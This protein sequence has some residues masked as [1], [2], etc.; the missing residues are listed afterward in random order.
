M[1]ARGNSLLGLSLAAVLAAS[2][3]GADVPSDKAAQAEVLFKD[4]RALMAE[5]KFDDACPKLRASQELDPGYGTLWNL[6]ECLSKQGKT[7]SAWATFREAAD[8][9][10]KAE[11]SERV[12]KAERRASELE[13][14]LEKL[15]ISV[16]VEVPGIVVKRDGIEVARAIW[17]SALPVD[18]GKHR[19]E[20]TAPGK[21]PWRGEVSTKGP[22]EAVSLVIP[23][24]V[25]LPVAVA[26][27][28]GGPKVVADPGSPGRRTAGLIAGS[29]GIAG[30][31][32]GA[33]FGGLASGKWS[34]AQDNHCRTPTLCDAEG[35]ALAG[36]AQTFAA[37]STGLFIGGGVLAAAGVT[38]YVTGLGGKK[39]KAGLSLQPVVGAQNGL[40]LEGQF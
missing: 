9:A 20:A 18:P 36:D 23:A 15:S 19:I 21:T 8:M 24:L 13:P 11:Q 35:V 39:S 30:I 34:N 3:A 5:G 1:R 38:L 6:G 12:E 26:P 2:A 4:G 16:A 32:A 33:V 29:A 28:G 27:P 14:R 40:T 17:G 25:D 10:R 22:G 7:A 31:L 37:A